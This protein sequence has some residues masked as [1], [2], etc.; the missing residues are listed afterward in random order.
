MIVM[1][2]VMGI[3]LWT[4][5]ADSSDVGIYDGGDN[6]GGARRACARK[7]AVLRSAWQVQRV[8]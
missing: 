1:V 4:D 2:M 8:P 7:T 3:I 6:V 5:A